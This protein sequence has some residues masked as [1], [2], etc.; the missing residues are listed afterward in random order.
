MT[1]FDLVFLISILAICLGLLGLGIF[2]VFRQWAKMKWLG[3][4]LVIYVILYAIVLVGVSLLS[5]QKVMAM[6]Q[7]RCYDDWC[8]S[9]ENVEQRTAIGPIQANGSFYLVTIKVSSRAKQASQRALD[10]G[11]YLLDNQGIRYDLSPAGQNALASAGE[12]GLPM[13]S[14]VEAGGSF[15]AIVVFDLPPDTT[16]LSLV[17]VLGGFPGNIIIGDD[18][19]ILHKPTIVELK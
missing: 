17:F 16:R 9:V 1:I 15:N 12:A 19:S 14:R 18:Q 7:A 3:L 11:A 6:H 13:D 2:L 4:G 8:A 10:A 5:P